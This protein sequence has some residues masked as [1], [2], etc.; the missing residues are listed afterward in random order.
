MNLM[1]WAETGMQVPDY[2]YVFNDDSAT[3]EWSCHQALLIKQKLSS[4]FAT[5]IIVKSFQTQDSVSKHFL[6]PIKKPAGFQLAKYRSS[7]LPHTNQIHSTFIKL[8]EKKLSSLKHW[9]VASINTRLHHCE[10]YFTLQ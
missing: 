7:S 8:K 6:L 3:S 4:L 2:Y 1:M 10:K 5:S 9:L